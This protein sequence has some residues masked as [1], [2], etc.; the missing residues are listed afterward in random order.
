MGWMV[1]TTP[2]TIPRRDEYME[3]NK[4]KSIYWIR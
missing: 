3:E 1:V 2:Y 4:T